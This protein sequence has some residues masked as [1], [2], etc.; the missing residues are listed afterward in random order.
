VLLPLRASLSSPAPTPSLNLNGQLSLLHE[1]LSVDET[2]G[3]ATRLIRTMGVVFSDSVLLHIRMAR[4]VLLPSKLTQYP[5]PEIS[6]FRNLYR[7]CRPM[8]LAFREGKNR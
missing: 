8:S 1:R 7:N 2:S 5:D 6:T 3:G 4:P